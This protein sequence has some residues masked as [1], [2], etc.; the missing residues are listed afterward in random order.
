MNNN[1]INKYN[2]KMEQNSTENNIIRYLGRCKWFSNKLGYGFITYNSKKETKD[3]FVHWSHLNIMDN[4][5]KTLYQGEYVEFTIIQCQGVSKTHLTQ[6]A[7]VTGPELGPLMCTT[8]KTLNSITNGSYF[9]NSNSIF[10]VKQISSHSI[11]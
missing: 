8:N 6:A 4:D 3:I 2:N 5:F 9:N 7:G 11:N 10:K 1:N